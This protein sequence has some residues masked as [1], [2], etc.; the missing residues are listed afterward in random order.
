MKKKNYKGRCERRTL[1]KCSDVCRLFSKI[2]SAYAELLDNNKNIVEF[3]CN[4]PLEGLDIGD[5]TTDF[6]A[7]KTDGTYLVRECV[8]RNCI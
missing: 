1:K 6:L 3:T 7:K 5:Y 8:E 2:Q 4:V